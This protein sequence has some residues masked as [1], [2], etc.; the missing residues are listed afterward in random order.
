MP[1]ESDQARRRLYRIA[2]NFFN[3]KPD[4]GVRLLVE[5]GF[6]DDDP[7][8]IAK[9]FLTRRGLGKQMI[10]EFLGTLRSPFHA[11]VL[12]HVLSEIQMSGEA[13]DNALKDM[14][15]FF[16]LP[17]EAQKIDYVMQVSSGAANLY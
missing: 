4:R 10:G 11:A 12:E 2:L 13:I 6:V 8:A 16:R 5:W 7:R 1:R 9:F 17:S 14:L 3:K 15:H